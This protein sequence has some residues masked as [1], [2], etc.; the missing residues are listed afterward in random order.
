MSQPPGSWDPYSGQ[1]TGQSG[2][3]YGSGPGPQN[4]YGSG[5]SYPAPSPSQYSPSQYSPPP[6][7]GGYP[8]AG[9]GPYGQP[10]YPG[11]YGQ[12]YGPPPGQPGLQR[13]G[14]ALAAAV[15]GYI[16]AGIVL[17]CSFAVLAAGTAATEALLIGILQL[18]SV[19][20]LIFGAVQLSTG[21]GR[22][23]MLVA[24]GLQLLLV[25]YYL[26]R[27]S[28]IGNAI[29]LGSDQGVFIVVPLFFAVMPA[30]ALGLTLN[31]M[32]PPYIASKRTQGPTPNTS[33]GQ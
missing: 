19:G 23:M 9:T 1:S 30:V 10:A 14:A 3:Q 25:V 7:Y 22:T 31:R 26:I 27:F 18:I 17:L 12:Q 24:S 6:A 16:Q 29:D 4:P 15:L 5:E 20:L 13:P 8:P 32:I 21:T 28:S 11:P 2:G 33:W